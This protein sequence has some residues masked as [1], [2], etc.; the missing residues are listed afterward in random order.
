MSLTQQ[1]ALDVHR[2]TRRGQAPPPPP[3]ALEGRALTIAFRRL[4]AAWRDRARTGA[5]PYRTRG[6]GAGS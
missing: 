4:R 3:G 6:Y 2:L 1:Y 5:H